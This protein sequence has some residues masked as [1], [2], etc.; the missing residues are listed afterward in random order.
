MMQATIVR[1]VAFT[2]AASCM[3][4]L[5]PLSVS[6]TTTAQA[7]SSVAFL[8][9]SWHCTGDGP[10]EDDVYTFTKNEWRD[11]D[12]L[13]GVT[14]GTFDT[15]RQKWVVF[16]MDTHGHYGVNEGPPFA[17]G[18]SHFTFPY[19]PDMSSHAFTFTKL[20]DSKFMLG[21]QTCTKQ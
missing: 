10:P 21:K 2:I 11:T 17:N 4:A 20:S 16:F 9:G 15:K 5:V 12:N 14:T 3:G 6:A 13:G 8:R 7:M 19:P 18:V 1:R